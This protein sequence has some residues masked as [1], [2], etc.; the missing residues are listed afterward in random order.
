VQRSDYA[1]QRPGQPHLGEQR[2]A[3]ASVAGD[4]RPVAQNEPPALV[5]RLLGYAREQA[6]G[7]SIGE[8][9]QRQLLAPVE[10]GDDPRRPPAELSGAGI[11]ENRSREARDRRV[12]G[13][14]A[15]WHCAGAYAVEFARC[16]RR[17]LRPLVLTSDHSNISLNV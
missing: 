5:P 17:L 14:S 9:K 12:V 4:W 1:S 13:V 6:T 15:S 8:R 2:Y 11:E 7:L 16:R 10:P 3:A